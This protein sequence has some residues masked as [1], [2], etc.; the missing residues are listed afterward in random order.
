V[1]V[2]SSSVTLYSLGF[3]SPRTNNV[4]RAVCLFHD[5]CVYIVASGRGPIPYFLCV[6]CSTSRLEFC[7]GSGCEVIGIRLVTSSK[8]KPCCCF[9]ITCCGSPQE[10]EWF[11][12]SGRVF[13]RGSENGV[14]T[15]LWSQRSHDSR[16]AA[17]R[18]LE[19][20]HLVLAGEK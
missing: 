14:R 6:N 17:V 16:S 5:I 4:D 7:Q 12:Y 9:E 11:T 15:I 8:D 1:S 10:V 2:C 3:L 19:F 20:H 13:F 18:S